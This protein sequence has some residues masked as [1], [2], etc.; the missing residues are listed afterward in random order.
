MPTPET[1]TSTGSPHEAPASLAVVVAVRGPGG[2][3]LARTRKSLAAADPAGAGELDVDP[4]LEVVEVPVAP[5]DEDGAAWSQ[6]AAQATASHVLLLHDGDTLLPGVLADLRDAIGAAD[7]VRLGP[8]DSWANAPLPGEAAQPELGAHLAARRD[9][10]LAAS[11]S[12]DGGP[13]SAVLLDRR[14]RAMASSSTTLHDRPA[15][16]CV[17]P[18]AESQSESRSEVESQVKS[19]SEVKLAAR[20]T[21]AEWV[22]GMLRIEVEATLARGDGQPLVDGSDGSD[23]DGA[24][25]VASPADVVVRGRTSRRQV[26]ASGRF[27]A[28]LVP[29][30]AG[31]DLRWT[32]TVDVDPST[33]ASGEPG[34]TDAVRDLGV[35]VVVAGGSYGAFVLGEGLPAQVAVLDGQPAVVYANR[36]QRLSLDLDGSIRSLAGTGGAADS[37]VQLSGSPYLSGLTVRVGFPAA[38]SFGSARRSAELWVSPDMTFA[39]DLVSDGTHV[40]VTADD[41]IAP[42]GSY[43]LGLRAGDKG[44]WL[45]VRLTIDEYG[46]AQVSSTG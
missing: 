30:D 16:R 46:A 31:S 12:P 21:S 13:P 44:G 14:L 10:V 34:L 19:E 7:V 32:G 26:L 40:T 11:G 39:A 41:V 33:A 36:V 9:L 43:R 45:P 17:A 37:D 28:E 20:A 15:V 8:P 24:A 25:L 3:G 42:P 18:P 38:R 6:G 23:G 29:H 5:T 27:T 4:A 2:E 1:P 22:D 35:R